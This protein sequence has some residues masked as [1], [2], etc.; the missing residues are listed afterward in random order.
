M[1][2]TKPTTNHAA[3]SSIRL[4]RWVM[5][6]EYLISSAAKRPRFN[7]EL[8]ELRLQSGALQAQAR[9]RAIGSPELAMAFPQHLKNAFALL[10]AE[11]RRP[12]PFALFNRPFQLRQRRLQHRPRRQDHRTLH[13]VLQF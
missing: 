9:S 11:L 3:A 6:K 1:W 12:A 5:K 10:V 2:A 7:S 8:V 13:K 4:N